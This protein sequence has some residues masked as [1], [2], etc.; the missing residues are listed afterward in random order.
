MSDIITREDIIKDKMI[1]I[2]EDNYLVQLFK[3]A[4][5]VNIGGEI[6]LQNNFT[7]AAMRMVEAALEERSMITF[8]TVNKGIQNVYYVV[9][10]YLKGFSDDKPYMGLEEFLLLVKANKADQIIEEAKKTFE[11]RINR[12]KKI[13]SKSKKKI[14]WGDIH[15]MGTRELLEEIDSDLRYCFNFP[16]TPANLRNFYFGSYHDLCKPVMI[17]KPTGIISLEKVVYGLY[18][19]L[20]ILTKF[21]RKDIDWICRKYIESIQLEVPFNLFERVIN[22]YLFA[23]L[24]S[25]APEKLQISKIDASLIIREIK[26]GAL[27]SEELIK[28]FIEKYEFKDYE[29]AYLKKYGA[30]LQKRL[31]SLRKSNYFGELFVITKPK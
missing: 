21:D 11:L 18:S 28:N 1:D 22:N 14:P 5:E 4:E 7:F 10:L 13:I 26:M 24:Y 3:V 8:E 6:E 19:E 31:D 20:R 12:L 30:H 29:I 25:D 27:N 2:K 16:T 15:Y 9:E 17:T 23:T